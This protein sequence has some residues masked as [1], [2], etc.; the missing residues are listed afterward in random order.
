MSSKNEVYIQAQ[1]ACALIEMQ[2]MVAANVAARISRH[3]HERPCT[4]LPFGKKDFDELII[5]YGIY[6]NATVTLLNEP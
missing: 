2:G 4:A 1:V 3:P 6:H 5:K